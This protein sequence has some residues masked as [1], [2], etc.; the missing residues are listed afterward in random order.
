MYRARALKEARENAP[1]PARGKVV[2]TSAPPSSRS[3]ASSSLSSAPMARKPGVPAMSGASRGLA[4]S[5]LGRSTVGGRGAAP[6][7]SAALGAV[8]EAGASSSSSAAAGGLLSPAT[9]KLRVGSKAAALGLP[10]IV[11]GIS[12]ALQPDAA[13]LQK[14]GADYNRALAL[15][16]GKKEAGQSS[17]VRAPRGPGWAGGAAATAGCGAQAA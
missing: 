14:W 9:G 11:E 1:P 13:V 4:T 3:G 10:S 17:L 5:G 6:A 16:W 7:P 12:K 8:A 15:E 2:G